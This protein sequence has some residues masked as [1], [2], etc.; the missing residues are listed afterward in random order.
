M[1]TGIRLRL[2]KMAMRKIK[3]LL[4]LPFE[5]NASNVREA[6]VGAMRFLG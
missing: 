4:Q 1:P 6:A 3:A 2:A 5:R